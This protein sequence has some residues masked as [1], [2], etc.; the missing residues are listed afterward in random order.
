MKKIYGINN[1]KIS[2]NKDWFLLYFYDKRYFYNVFYNYLFYEKQFLYKKFS[3][4]KYPRFRC[5]IY[6]INII[7]RKF[8]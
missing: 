3:I 7:N 1:K 4:K 5:K 2:H 6:F 8:I